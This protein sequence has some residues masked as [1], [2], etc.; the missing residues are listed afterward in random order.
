MPK[1]YLKNGYKGPDNYLW[2]L[3]CGEGRYKPSQF[4]EYRDYD[5]K[6]GIFTMKDGSLGL[7]KEFY[8]IL[9]LDES[10]LKALKDIYSLDL[11]RENDTIQVINFATDCIEPYLKSYL[12]KKSRNNEVLWKYCKETVENILEVK[13]KGYRGIFPETYTPK[14]FLVLLTFRTAASNIKRLLNPDGIKKYISIMSGRSTANEIEEDN[15]NEIERVLR[16]GKEISILLKQAGT[17]I[18]DFAPEELKWFI[19]QLFGR[20]G[21]IRI[22][23]HRTIASQIFDSEMYIDIGNPEYI[24]TSGSDIGVFTVKDYPESIYPSDTSNMLGSYLSDRNQIP[25]NTLTCLNLKVISQV[26]AKEMIQKKKA[27]HSFLKRIK[28]A[29]EKVRELDEMEKS[30][31]EGNHMHEGY[32]TFLAV[33]DSS[34]RYDINDTMRRLSSQIESAGY[35]A[36]KE[37]FIKLPIFF[38]SL[39]LNFNFRNLDFFDRKHQLSAWNCASMAPYYGDLKGNTNKPSQFFISRR[40]QEY[41][42]DVFSENSNDYAVIIFGPPGT[43][44]SFLIQTMAASYLAEDAIAVITEVG[45]SYENS[46]RLLK[47]R[48]IDFNKNNDISFNPFLNLESG[49]IS[50]YELLN[51]TN[52]FQFMVSPKE[53]LGE[54]KIGY[55][56]KAIRKV[57]DDFGNKGNIEK[58][59]SA[60]RSEKHKDLADCLY[61][62]SLK[63]MYGNLCDPGKKS[64]SLDNNLTSIALPPIEKIGE[65]LLTFEYMAIFSKISSI[66]YSKN[67]YDRRKF[68]T[69]D[70][71]HNVNN[72]PFLSP[73]ISKQFRQYRKCFASVVIGT[74]SLEDVH[75]NEY[76]KVL[77]DSASY[78]IVFQQKSASIDRLKN[79]HKLNLGNE[80]TEKL[81]RSIGGRKGAYSEFMLMTPNGNTL[82]RHI[83]SPFEKV[84][85]GSEAKEILRIEELEKTGMT[86]ADAVEK[87]VIEEKIKMENI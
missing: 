69:Y 33:R 31:N 80:A 49:I 74:Q 61:N 6:T 32:L 20:K 52:L 70:E 85:F 34:K 47:G 23:P 26:K 11:L 18:R 81:F 1:S 14:D 64:F 22:N 48:Y 46:T 45:H 51:F 54:D 58:V 7:I 9:G 82:L 41:S 28:G 39:P 4:V 63:G 42:F 59:M 87:I 16:I 60:L 5:Y 10:R 75:C 66:V 38:N 17:E 62:Y 12:A 72:N 29:G 86:L 73:M 36:Q 30:I 44:K 53:Q 27:R 57:A 78:Q 40:S 77:A 15:R 84:L 35:L 67:F 56:S 65:T 19:D 76:C 83:G 55:L 21:T 71:Y 68:I 37:T 3:M 13:Q 50:N 8:P 2:N 79:E 24:K 25:A 43:G